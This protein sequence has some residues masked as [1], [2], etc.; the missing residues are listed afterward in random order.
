MMAAGGEGCGKG[1]NNL[2][3]LGSDKT[4]QKATYC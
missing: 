4:Y 3:T 2:D 1:N